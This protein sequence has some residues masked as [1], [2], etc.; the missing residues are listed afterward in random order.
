MNIDDLRIP[1]NAQFYPLRKKITKSSI[2]AL[3]KEISDKKIG[4]YL[5]REVR[6]QMNVAGNEIIYSFIAFKLESEPSFLHGTTIK[7]T[8]YAFL[9]VIE[10]GTF[11]AVFKK[12]VDSPEKHLFKYL[13]HSDYD[14]FCHFMAGSGP[15]YEKVGMHNMSISD[16][17]IRYKALEAH[18][19]NGIMSA[20]SAQRAIPS[21]FRMRSAD[22]VYTIT[23]GTSRLSKKDKKESLSGIIK[24]T[25]AAITEID[26]NTQKSP[27]INYFARPIDL[28]K[29][30]GQCKPISILFYFED[31][32]RDIR[33][34][35]ARKK[36]MRRPKLGGTLEELSEQELVRFFG[37]YRSPLAII[38]KDNVYCIRT[39]G[40]NPLGKLRFN[41]KE[42]S[43]TS[44][45]FESIV[46]ADE[47]GNQQSVLKYISILKP[48]SVVF[49]KPQYIY[50]SKDSFEDTRL[51]GNI[52]GML[53]ILIDD[54]DFSTVKS[55]KEKPHN[56]A[57]VEFPVKSLFKEV[58]DQVCATANIL[59]CD[60]MGDEWADH[61]SINSL[62]NP[63]E[64]SFIHSK[65][66]DRESMGASNFHEV[67][68]QAQKNLGRLNSDIDE[69]KRKF[70]Q[71]W[72]TNYESTNIGRSRKGHTWID[73]EAAL[74][75]VMQ[76]PNSIKK[77][78]LATPFISKGS[79]TADFLALKR[80][81]TAK[82]HVIQLLW[83]LNTFISACIENGARP[84]VLCKP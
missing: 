69:F 31:L 20:V 61:I 67:V 10:Y 28:G 4:G 18:S 57:I 70:D 83:L 36:L 34:D 38:E 11:I 77:V 24:W 23:P 84:Y 51:L 47:D 48:F 59:L 72:S 50:F 68:A 15:Q 80:D 53:S 29:I 37:F 2:N 40:V 27:F 63:P 76:N 56:A 78:I 43:I 54:F 13:E 41:K 21:S 62:C 55:E 12:H 49:D 33:G 52:D 19:L 17:V 45:F 5:L 58:E 30:I 46:I 16:S 35:G 25:I 7:E 3:F 60:D 32:D 73:V 14:K 71:K 22:E 64:I 39:K 8:T 81:G 82:P 75:V 66:I 9:L 44:A 74:R 1:K 42:I 65:Y 79:I 26:T 6:K